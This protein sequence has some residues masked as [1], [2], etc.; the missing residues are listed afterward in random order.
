M[1]EYPGEVQA[2][3]ASEQFGMSLA[4]EGRRAEAEHAL[5]ETV[6]L[7]R[8]SATGRSG[9]TGVTELS[10]AEI[11]LASGDPTCVIEAGK[12]LHTVEPEV[13]RTR[14]SGTSCTGFSSRPPA[15]PINAWLRP[16]ATLSFPP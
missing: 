12:L 16:Y 8:D 6:R 11:I 13:R 7:C 14:S 2:K 5:R 9:T 10:L 15:S 1:S 4:A 3:F